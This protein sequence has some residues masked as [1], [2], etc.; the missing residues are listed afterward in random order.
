[1]HH[2]NSYTISNIYTS[3]K[4][5]FKIIKQNLIFKNLFKYKNDGE[6]F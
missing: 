2:K 5:I 6:F 1:M 4:Y 3:R